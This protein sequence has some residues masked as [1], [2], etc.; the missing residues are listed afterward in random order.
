LDIIY[1]SDSDALRTAYYKADTPLSL[2]LY[3]E[4]DEPASGA[5][6]S[7]SIEIPNCQITEASVPVSDA[8][9]LTQSCALTAFDDGT[10][11]FVKMILVNNK[12]SAY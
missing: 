11:P 9:H 4:S 2:K 5:K 6:H 3:F 1:S 12:T 7:L 8:N 10:N